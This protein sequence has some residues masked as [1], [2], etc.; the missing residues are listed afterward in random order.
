MI[1][2]TVIIIR[3]PNQF[4][5]ERF[6]FRDPLFNY[7]I[8]ILFFLSFCFPLKR[9]TPKV[10]QDVGISSVEN[11]DPSVTTTTQYDVL[12]LPV[13]KDKHESISLFTEY[14]KYIKEKE[15]RENGSSVGELSSLTEEQTGHQVVAQNINLLD[16]E[17]FNNNNF[18]FFNNRQ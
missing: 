18:F 8:T 7:C 14:V 9:L 16:G 2:E 11:H 1:D 10:V 4:E 5:S 15:A 13:A 3:N 12:D 17:Y 6:K